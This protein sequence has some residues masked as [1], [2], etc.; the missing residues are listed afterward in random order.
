MKPNIILIEVD[1]MRGDCMGAA[2][3]PVVGT[4][5]IDNMARNGYLFSRAYSATPTC[6]PARAAILTGMSQKSHGRVGYMERVSWNYE[7]TI[8][9]EF[10]KGGYHTQA[11]GKMHVYPTRSLCGFHNVILHDGYLH[12]CRNSNTEYGEHFN[13]CDDY[14]NWL[15]DRNINIDLLDSGLDC[16]S[17]VARPWMYNEELH[18]TNWVTSQSIDFLRRRDPSKPFFLKMSYVRPHSPLDPPEVYYNQYINE[19]IPESPV[20]NW[21]DVE[22]KDRAGWIVDCSKGVINKKALKRAKAAY[23]ALITHID[24]QIG[25]FLQALNE[26]GCLNNSIILFTSDHGDLMGD[27]NLFRK[28]YPYQGSISIPFIVYDPGNILQNKRGKA[29]SE[30]VELRDIMPTLLDFA[31]LSIPDTVEGKSVRE[32]LNDNTKNTFREY[33]HGE[34]SGGTISNHY[35][36]TKEDKYIWYSQTGE[37]QYFDLIKDPRELKNLSLEEKYT[38]RIEYLKSIL[39]KELSG[40]EEGYTNEKELIAGKKPKACLNHIINV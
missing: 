36:V 6:I 35:I 9:S 13:Q 7:N 18:P 17:W 16:N 29:I 14:L 8:A 28:T 27:H 21:A 5:Y 15:K 24:H 31:G 10:A 40:R 12:Y 25:R 39:I 11:I 22:D 3:H 33:I 1:Q 26:H 20:G 19:D 38:G 34:H 4:P 32:L 2:G 37:E 23:Y 30:I